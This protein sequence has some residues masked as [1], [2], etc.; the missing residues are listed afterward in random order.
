MGEVYGVEDIY[1]RREMNNIVAPPLFHR[2][3]QQIQG[4]Q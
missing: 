2:P 3:E 4:T 1:L